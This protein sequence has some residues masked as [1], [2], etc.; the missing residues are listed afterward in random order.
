[1]VSITLISTE[2]VENFLHLLQ[3]KSANKEID[4]IFH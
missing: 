1:M 3:G 4:D 2:G